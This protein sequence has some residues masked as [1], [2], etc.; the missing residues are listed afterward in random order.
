[1]LIGGATDQVAVQLTGRVRPREC[2]RPRD[3]DVAAA[4]GGGAR[5]DRRPPQR[6]RIGAVIDDTGLRRQRRRRAPGRV[7]GDH[8]H[9][10]RRTHLTAGQHVAGA[11]R[12]TDIRAVPA[13]A[14]TALPLIRIPGRLTIPPTRRRRQDLALAGGAGDLRTA[15]IRRHAAAAVVAFEAGVEG[16]PDRRRTRRSE[17]AGRVA[18]CGVGGG[19]VA[20]GAGDVVVV[21]DLHPRPAE[22]VTKPVRTHR[23]RDRAGERETHPRRIHARGHGHLLGNGNEPARHPGVVGVDH[24]PHMLI[25]GA[26]DQVAVQLTGRVRPRE[27]V[28]PRDGDVAVAAGGGARPDRRPPQRLRIGAVI[29]DT[30]LRRQRR[31]RAAGRVRGDHRHPHRRTNIPRGQRVA[32]AGRR[33]DIGAVPAAAIT[34]LPLIRIPGRLTIPPTRRRRQDL[35]LAGGAGDFGEG[36]V[37]RCGGGGGD[38]AGRLR[39]GRGGGAGGVGGADGDPDRGGDVAA[40]QGVGGVGGG[41]DVGAGLAGVVA[42][43]PL[44]AVAGR[45]VRPAAGGG[46]QLAGFG[47]GAADLGWGL[48]GGQVRV[49]GD[50]GGLVGG[51]GGGAAPAGPADRGSVSVRV[52]AVAGCLPVRVCLAGDSSGRVVA[53]QGGQVEAVFAGVDGDARLL[54]VGVVAV[55]GRVAVW[56]GDRGDV[57]GWVVDGRGRLRRAGSSR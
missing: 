17:L 34:A 24:R 46:G 37:G 47:W 16:E 29:D 33:T 51:G 8:R 5:P 44:V 39:A 26:T 23:Q 48:V 6:L 18:G 45:V 32:G 20:A 7:R 54:V 50:E 12:R 35:V 57:S 3:G 1:M 13:A 41:G 55:A 56:V 43:L 15:R 52:V 53:G 4:A 14:I 42:A 21:D 2:V 11:G 9:P 22:P 49:D 31:R 10:H 38:R 30:G 25:G 36:L 28:R 40:G 19:D 27:C